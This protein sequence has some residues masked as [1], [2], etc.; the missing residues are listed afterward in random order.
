MCPTPFV[1]YFK[2]RDCKIKNS[3][4]NHCVRIVGWSQQNGVR[5]WLAANSHGRK[6][7]K[8]GWFKIE[9]GHNLKQ[10]EES[11]SFINP[12]LQALPEWVK[13]SG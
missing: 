7:G 10:I 13:K 6:F 12:D 11:M 8:N 9:M 2:K 1:S 3:G 4:Q 5:Y